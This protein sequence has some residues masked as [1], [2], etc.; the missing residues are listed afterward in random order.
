[1]A[2]KLIS[3]L[4]PHIHWIIWP[5]FVL[6]MRNVYAYN[7]LSSFDDR[8][9]FFCSRFL[10]SHRFNSIENYALW[11]LPK[12]RPRPNITHFGV[13]W[14]PGLIF[15][16]CREMISSNPKFHFE[17]EVS[18]TISE[19]PIELLQP[20]LRWV[21]LAFLH[22]LPADWSKREIFLIRTQLVD[23]SSI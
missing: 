16:F 17:Q 9:Y 3:M 1:M 6:P 4:T 22:R 19:D 13:H 8:I 18:H 7:G 21:H 11:L 14:P 23:D 10:C 2:C 20:L 5:K 12:S 15:P